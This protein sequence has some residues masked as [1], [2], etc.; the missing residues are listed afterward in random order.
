LKSSKWRHTLRQP[1]TKKAPNDHSNN[2]PAPETRRTPA[3][4][5]GT[6]WTRSPPGHRKGVLPA[7]SPCCVS[8]SGISCW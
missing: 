8:L 2:N 1:Q 3:R 5:H 4:L 6:G 7:P